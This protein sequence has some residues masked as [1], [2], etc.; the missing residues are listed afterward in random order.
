MS[1]SLLY[2]GWGLRGYRHCR[3]EYQE[4]AIQFVIEHAPEKLRCS[5]CGSDDVIRA[6]QVPRRFRGLP[7]GSRR[8]WIALSV[9]RL[10]CRRCGRTRQADLGFA[11]ERLSYIR[12]FE[13]YALELSRHMT[14]QAVAQHLGVGWDMIKDIQKRHLT[15]RF[16]RIR[17]KKLR[18]IAIDEI[19]IGKGHR[20]FTVVLDLDSGAVVFIGDGKGAES[21]D[22]FWKSLR[23]SRAK[24]RAVATDMSPAYILAV[25]ENL[26]KALHVF[27]RFHVVKL[28]N[29]KLSDLRRHVQRSAET[30]EQKKVIKGTRWLLLK[31]PDK[32]DDDRDERTRLDEALRLNQPLATAYYLKEDLR[33]LWE[34]PGKRAAGKFLTDWIKRAHAS[35]VAML[36]KF[37]N[38]LQLHRKGL[39]AWYNEP[40]STG[41]LEGTNNKIKTMQRQSYGFRDPEFFRLKIFA[42]H[43]ANYALVG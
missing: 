33:Q 19:S 16:K 17:L 36:K 4:G 43:E 20:Y 31:T 27:D 18:R 3:T 25:H 26:P 32:L 5:C 13:R 6:G 30:I 7:I 42:I 21:L 29:E 22:S 40:I 39:L 15:R 41:P 14:I 24:V 34:Q 37:A 10:S 2:H 23:A 11:D 12:P 1:T 35:G 28:F 38:T 9:Q 8:T